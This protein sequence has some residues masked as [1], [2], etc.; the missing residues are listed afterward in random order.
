MNSPNAVRGGDLFA[1]CA[2]R[3]VISACGRYRYKLLRQWNT[4]R[5]WLAWIMLNPSTA[6]AHSDDPTI[7]VCIGR[8]HRM[9]FGGII[10]VN[11]FALRATDP[12]V[13]KRH[14]APVGPD[15]DQHIAASVAI[16]DMTICAWGRGGDHRGRDAE[17]LPIAM[18]HRHDRQLWALKLT[19]DAQPCHPLRIG[20][21]VEPFVWKS[22]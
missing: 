1:D 11:L 6:D 5:P 18:R 19:K 9:Q 13:M 14:P 3:A 2:R 16:A 15:N 22:A 17:V 4:A 20:Y 21:A 10:V 12:E 8:A 7:R